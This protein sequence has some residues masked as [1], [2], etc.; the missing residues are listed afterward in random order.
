MNKITVKLEDIKA[1]TQKALVNHGASERVAESVAEAVKVAEAENNKVC[2]LYYLES[3]CNQL[4]SNR[5]DGSV[6]PE[7]KKPSNSSVYVDAKN[8]FAQPA[9]AAGFEMAVC[10]ARENGICLFTIAH[11]HTCT[12][13]GF[14]TS[15]IAK[16]GL[17]GIGA[18]V[19]P[20]CVSP[21]GG[22]KPLLGT[23]PI[24]M[25]V[26][27]KNNDVAFQFDQ[28]TSAIAIGKIRMAA[29]NGESIPEGWAV[30]KEGKPTTDPNKALEGSLLSSGGYKGFGFGL[31]AELLASA[32]TGSLSSVNAPPLKT[33]EGAPHDLGQTYILIDPNFNGEKD[34]FFEQINSLTELISSQPNARLPGSNKNNPSETDIDKDLWDLVNK[35][36]ELN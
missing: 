32:L 35:L 31:M 10:T 2:G 3:Y 22:N 18:T 7:V 14:F 9:F 23:N 29:S 15:Q 20:A 1:Q 19:A 24:S 21:P 27:S 6:M 12:S 16:K 26:P 8:G 34:H 28:S 33:T 36:A 17:L 30:D 4:K 5:V 25:S 11:S 13:M